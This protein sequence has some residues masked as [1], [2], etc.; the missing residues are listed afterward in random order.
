MAKRKMRA[1][2]RVADGAGRMVSVDDLRFATGEWPISFEVPADRADHWIAHL[3]A[4]CSERRWS[5]HG[6][7]E[8]E[9]GA[10]SGSKVVST[11][12]AGQS[13]ALQIVW[14]RTRGGPISIRAR[15]AGTPALSP[16]A[17]R[18]FLDAVEERSRTGTTVRGH[19][20]AHLHYEGLPWRGEL[21]LG[22]SLRLGPPSRHD[23]S[24]LLAPQ[25]II[26]DAEVEGIG[27]Q[28]VDSAFG[29]TLRELC[30]FLGAVVGI[31]AKV[32]ESSR[33]WTYEIDDA[34]KVA[35]CDV[36]HLGYWETARPGGMPKRG[37]GPPVPLRP[38]QR[39]GLERSGIWPDDVEQAVPEDLARL[40]QNLQDLGPRERDQFFRAGN[41]YL[42]ARSIWPA[43]RTAYAAF[44]V[45]ACESLKP[46]GRRYEGC[47]VY[48]VVE[49]L[50]GVAEAR[51]LRQ[52]R[53]APQRVRSRHLHRGELVAGELVPRLLQRHFGDPS[54]HETASALTR[55]TRACLVEWLRRGGTYALARRVAGRRCT[56]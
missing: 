15:P 28:G 4:E 12:I 46:A 1:A 35:R 41:A 23:P 49:G 45:V 29:L 36:R 14:E 25:V 32:E 30:I 7:G 39:P 48:D 38:V 17:A 56:R 37:D 16:E 47:N 53:L 40:W 52:L 20:R 51:M 19:R 44:M 50:L 9:A 3:V 21:W 26:V 31:A 5:S 42:I 6:V 2:V 13:P 34:G 10:N 11:G 22:E 8:L 55:I 33:A 27:W 43:Q 54:F 24:S 18:G